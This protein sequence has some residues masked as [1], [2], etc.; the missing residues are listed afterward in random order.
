LFS[1]PILITACFN[2][3]PRQHLPNT[4]GRSADDGVRQRELAEETDGVNAPPVAK[5]SERPHP[6]RERDEI[7]GRL[8]RPVAEGARGDQE[9][10]ERDN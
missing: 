7:E 8:P 3:V 1:A 2:R 10:G 5:R 6:S 4:H 9:L